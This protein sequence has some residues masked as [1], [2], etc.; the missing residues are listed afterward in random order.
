MRHPFSGLSGLFV[1]LI[2]AALPLRAQTPTDGLMMSKGA[3]CAAAVY[4]GSQWKEYWEGTNFRSSPNLGTVSNQNIML[5]GALGITDRL[6]AIVALPYV[7]TNASASYLA[8]QRGFQDVS[9]WLKYR[10]VK[11]AMLSGTFSTFVTGGVSAP[12][13]NY[14]ADFLPLS[15]G[16]RSKTASA[17]LIADYYHKSGLYVTAQAGYT[18]RSN[19]RIDRDSYLFDNRMYYTNEVQVP[20]MADG[21]ARL[22]FRNARFQTD[23]W[24][25]RFAGLSGDDIRYNEMPFLT[26]AMKATTI[27]WYG[28]YNIKDFSVT[29]GLNRVVAGR[30]AGQSTG[31]SV[32]VLY[33]F[34]VFGHGECRKPTEMAQPE[35]AN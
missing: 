26:N 14:V 30:N 13:A 19:V 28:R 20:D 24:I 34:R 15:I 6:N 8:G 10:V 16:M 5:M 27:G 25:D 17:R 31:F 3:F 21:T 7:K 29:G 11:Q 33:A 9:V 18:R 23:V 22:G 2:A 1:F 32:G 12:T 4:S 35:P